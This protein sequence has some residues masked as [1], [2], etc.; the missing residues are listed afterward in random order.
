MKGEI[1]IIKGADIMFRTY[2]FADLCG[3]FSKTELTENQK[4]ELKELQ[5]KEKCTDKQTE[6]MNAL[7]AK[8]DA[9]PELDQTAKNLVQ[10]IFRT[11]IRGTY[12]EKIG[13]MYTKKG[14]IQEDMAI[15]RIARVN[16]WGVCLNANR[17][18]EGRGIELKDHIGVGH[19]DAYKPNSHLGFD[20]KCSFTDATFPLFDENLKSKQYEIQAKRLA[21]LAGFDKWHVCY[22]LE[23]SPEEVVISHA[24]KLWKEAGNFGQLTDSFIDEVR[25]LHRFDHLSDWER[26]KMFTVKLEQS[27]IDLFDKRAK[28]AREYFDTLTEKYLTFKSK[29]A[30]N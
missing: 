29:V 24:W 22:S 8:R 27:D 20:A 28:M 12:T 10:E 21:M 30:K 4:V 14:I 2:N 16:G 15:Q 5:E 13:N 18:N 19:P 26:V 9:K 23:N 7:I 11:V 3:S 6:K 25:A 1:E 17:Q